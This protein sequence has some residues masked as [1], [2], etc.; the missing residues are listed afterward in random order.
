MA[1]TLG[2]LTR[3]ELTKELGITQRTLFRWETKGGLPCV[4]IG[5]SRYYIIDSVKDWLKQFEGVG[6]PDDQGET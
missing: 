4:R 5:H 6:P 1:S 3:K 2:I